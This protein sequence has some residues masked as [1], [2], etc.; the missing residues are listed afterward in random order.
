MW[1][2][3][4][5]QYLRGAQLLDEENRLSAMLEMMTF[6]KQ[7]NESIQVLLTRFETVRQRSRDD[8]QY[9]MSH[10]C[11][12][13]TLLRAIGINER[14]LMELLQPLGQRLPRDEQEFDNMCRSLV[15]MGR[16]LENF[17]PGQGTIL[18]TISNTVGSADMP[19]VQ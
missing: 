8:G 11:Y 14:Q 12:A 16:F 5:F 17:P 13:L 18:E 1:D 9:V 10:E 2:F 3:G 7:A 15:R 4:R 6:H 19:E